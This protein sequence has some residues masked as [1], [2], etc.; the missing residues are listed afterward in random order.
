MDPLTLALAVG[1]TG[2]SILANMFGQSSIDKAR[3]RTIGEERDRQAGYDKEIG[4]LNTGAQNRYVGF[5]GQQAG[6]ATQLGDFL[7]GL[8]T[9]NAAGGMPV[10]NSTITQQAVAG[11]AGEA[12]ARGAQQDGALARLRSF[13]DVLGDISIGQA[14]DAG[15]IGQL[16]G[17]KTGSANIHGLELDAA[18]QQGGGAR[19]LGDI[20]GLIGQVGTRAAIGGGTNSIAGP[21]GWSTSVVGR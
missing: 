20:L 6:K 9:P 8:A 5:G 10:S 15:S 3:K 11:R 7:G 19:F 14:R 17:F 16:G 4:T 1:G 21:G 12:R 13:G 18:N 2:G